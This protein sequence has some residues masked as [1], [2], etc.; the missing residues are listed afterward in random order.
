MF[1]INK[2]LKFPHDDG[3]VNIYGVECVSMCTQI[4]YFYSLPR[5]CVC[6]RARVLGGGNG[7]LFVVK[8]V[9]KKT[10]RKL[11]TSCSLKY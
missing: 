1:R 3:G 7:R 6:E 11:N 2:T 9:R 8:T 5:A 10:Q 4:L